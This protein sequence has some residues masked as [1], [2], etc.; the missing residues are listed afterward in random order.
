MDEPTASRREQWRQRLARFG[1]RAR[2][3]AP[4]GLGMLLAFAAVLFYNILLPGPHVLTTS[5]MNDV[6]AHAMASA[7]PPPAFSERAYQAV[8]PSL[9]L[10]Q[11]HVPTTDGKTDGSLGSGVVLDDQGEILTSLHV[12]KQAIDIQVTFADGTQSPANLVDQQPDNDIAVLRAQHPP[13]QLVPAVLG[14]PGDAR[15]G[16]QVFA[17]GNPFGLYGSMSA[18][19]VSGLERPFQ[20]PN[21]G[22]KMQGLIQFDAAVNPGNSGGPLVNRDGEVIGIVTGLANPTG[23][24]VFIGIGFAVPIDVAASAAGS[25]PY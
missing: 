17:V 21:G 20:P 15:V 22:A 1:A 2:R 23:Q 24:D 9:V 11:A 14:N 19:V 4:V 8:A 12:V 7:T 3:A 25:P 13:A 18:G 6:V 16:D 10:I 5:E